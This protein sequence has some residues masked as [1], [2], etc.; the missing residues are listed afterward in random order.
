MMLLLEAWV[1][2]LPDSRD[3][4]STSALLVLRSSMEH[5]ST[6]A[7]A[8]VAAALVAA[9]LG[10]V[11]SVHLQRRPRDP[12]HQSQQRRPR[13]P[14]HQLVV[15]V[16]VVSCGAS[17]N[18]CY[19]PAMHALHCHS[20]DSQS[21]PCASR[22]PSAHARSINSIARRKALNV[23]IQEQC[24]TLCC[25]TLHRPFQYWSSIDGHDTYCHK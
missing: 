5:A 18:V 4:I 11:R 23:C 20:T 15:L 9:A 14:F 10:M 24:K 22:D 16:L 17:R 1:Q 25:S 3:Q 6:L 12:L 2:V 13:D 19:E 21:Q 8:L 7:Y